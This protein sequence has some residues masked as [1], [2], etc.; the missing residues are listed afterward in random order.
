MRLA[1]AVTSSGDAAMFR[2]TDV[3]NVQTIDLLLDGEFAT[4][5]SDIFVGPSLQVPSRKTT[6]WCWLQGARDVCVAFVEGVF[7]VLRM[8]RALR[9]SFV[10]RGTEPV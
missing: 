1:E 5:G 3:N 9:N 4:E 8:P 7:S 2:N 10:N 6:T